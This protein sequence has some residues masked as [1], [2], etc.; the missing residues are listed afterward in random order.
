MLGGARVKSAALSSCA[1]S[2]AEAYGSAKDMSQGALLQNRGL[3]ILLVPSREWP[4]L[5]KHLRIPKETMEQVFS[6]ASMSHSLIEPRKNGEPTRSPRLAAMSFQPSCSRCNSETK[7]G[8]HD[9]SG[10]KEPCP[11]IYIYIYP[12]FTRK[13]RSGPLA[14]LHRHE[15]A[16]PLA[17]SGKKEAQKWT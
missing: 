11:Y 10:I 3:V 12:G 14:E 6:R 13:L 15:S 7:Q 1:W 5:G 17:W 9:I 4:R 8:V 2:E 16:Q